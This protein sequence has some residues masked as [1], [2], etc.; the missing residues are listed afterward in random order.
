ME[1]K[2]GMYKK[3]VHMKN[4]RPSSIYVLKF[5]KLKVIYAINI[6]INAFQR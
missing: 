2:F 3:R 1:H 4:L 6:I 5:P